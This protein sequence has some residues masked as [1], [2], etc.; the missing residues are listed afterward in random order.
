MATELE[1]MV[2]YAN[3]FSPIKSHDLLIMWSCEITRQSKNIS[4]PVAGWLLTMR[5]FFP[6]YSTLW[7]DGL[8][9]SCA[10]LKPLYLHYHLAEW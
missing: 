7:S 9:R 8:V 3:G 6:C 4:P 2:T 1:R 10:K 5:G